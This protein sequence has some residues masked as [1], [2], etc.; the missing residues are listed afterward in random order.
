MGNFGLQ[1]IANAT[2]GLLNGRPRD[3]AADQ[4]AS[5]DGG[6]AGGFDQLF[7]HAAGSG[8]ANGV[9]SIGT[10]GASGA[11]GASGTS[12]ASGAGN[13][14]SMADPE[15]W[16]A[17]HGA[18]AGSP[19]AKSAAAEQLSDYLSMPLGK[20]MFYMM[21]ASMG[22]SQEQYDAMSPEDQAKVAAQVAQRL[23]ENAEA[24]SAAS[25]PQQG[26][27]VPAQPRT[28]QSGDVG[29]SSAPSQP[30]ARRDEDAVTAGV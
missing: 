15:Q 30:R 28:R 20:R 12:G 14:Y 27:G 16:A 19:G 17:A 9:P 7:R 5:G 23:K 24:A 10:S 22:I 29:A 21:L 25:Q 3:K 8:A 1:D 18:P 13:R 4:G 6:V 26:V 2:V 11:A